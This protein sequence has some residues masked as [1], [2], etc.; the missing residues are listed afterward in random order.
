MPGMS[1]QVKKRHYSLQEIIEDYPLFYSEKRLDE[2][3]GLFDERATI[4]RVEEGK[5]ISSLNVV[6]AM[7]EQR[8]YAEENRIFRETWDQVEIKQYGN[9]A[10]VKADYVLTTDHEIRKGIDI[11][12]LCF[13]EK[14]WW[15]TNLTYEQKEFI[16]R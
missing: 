4:V 11:L 5:P 10:V 2:W 8:E 15:I 14:G 7:P 3:Q 1:S 6:E 9:I 16:V 12:T 13:Y